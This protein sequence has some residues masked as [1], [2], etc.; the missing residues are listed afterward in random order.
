M[1]DLEGAPPAVERSGSGYDAFISYSH[2]LDGPLAMRLQTE[3]QRFAKPWNRRRSMRVFRD[4][5]SLS[6]SPA[7]WTSIA[8]ALDNS[9]FLVLLAS[10]EAAGSE[11]VSREVD[12][13]R[14]VKGPDTLLIALTAGEI[15]WDEELRGLRQGP[16][17]CIARLGKSPVH[18]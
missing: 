5:A 4:Q 7:L 8:N 12:R 17:E 9:R 15:V 1:R 16:D 10:P 11:W 14:E 2:A 6:A 18:L 13:W 3:L